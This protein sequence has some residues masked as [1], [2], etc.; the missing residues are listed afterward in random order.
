M[1][2]LG[3]QVPGGHVF[4]YRSSVFS[5]TREWLPCFDAIDQLALWVIE[6]E[7]PDGYTAITCGDLIVS[8]F[9]AL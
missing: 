9:N 1:D 4:T 7:V 6:L 8:F 3:N 5:S 2:K